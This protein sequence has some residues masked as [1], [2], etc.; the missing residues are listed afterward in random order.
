P[1]NRLEK[2]RR[3][4][5]S[6]RMNLGGIYAAQQNWVGAA[7]QFQAI[8]A[9]NPD[10]WQ[11]RSNLAD[12]LVSMG[13]LDEAIKEYRIALRGGSDSSEVWRRLGVALNKTDRRAEALKTL[14]EALRL[15][16]DGVAEINQLAWF[17]AT[18]PS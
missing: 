9:E 16:P 8:I 12:C 10:A 18:N 6:A 7:E 11:A 13:R 5:A 1:P 15:N 17:L 4:Q 2:A 14:R 3:W